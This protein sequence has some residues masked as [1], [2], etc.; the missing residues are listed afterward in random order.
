MTK[1]RLRL[2][3]FFPEL[4]DGH[5]DGPSLLDHVSNTA[6]ENEARIIDYLDN[7]AVLIASPGVNVDVLAPS[8]DTIGAAGILTD[9]VWAW[10]CELSYY[11]RKYHVKL[12]LDFIERMSRTGW[13][14]P[15]LEG[16]DLSTLEL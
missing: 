9:G 12:P 6:Q 3:G 13:Q 10:P 8:R 14:V 11:V 15:P 5:G 16:K 2:A 1:S 7:G 4:F